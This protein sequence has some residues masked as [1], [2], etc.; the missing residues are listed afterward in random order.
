[1]RGGVPRPDVGGRGLPVRGQHDRSREHGAPG[2]PRPRPLR[3]RVPRRALRPAGRSGARV[4][5]IQRARTVRGVVF[6]RARAARPREG[7]ASRGRPPGGLRDHRVEREAPGRDPV[8]PLRPQVAPGSRGRAVR[9]PGGPTRSSS[10]TRRS[11]SSS[12]IRCPGRCASSSPRPAGR[13]SRSRGGSSTPKRAKRFPASWSRHHP[14]TGRGRNRP[15]GSTA[16]SCD[17][18]RMRAARSSS[19]LWGPRST[20]WRSRTRRGS[21]CAS[22]T[23]APRWRVPR[24]GGSRRSGRLTGS[25]GQRSVHRCGTASP[26]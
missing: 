13:G 1:M 22:W 16:R 5:R 10:R 14:S 18:R 23:N 4:R 19:A 24:G 20:S 25:S 12:I 7:G 11:R 21:A 8:V 17:A 3:G 9:R 2:L 6:A 26:R 15:P